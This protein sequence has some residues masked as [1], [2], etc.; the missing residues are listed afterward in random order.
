VGRFMR[1]ILGIIVIVLSIAVFLPSLEKPINSGEKVEQSSTQ[2]SIQSISRNEI[3]RLTDEFI[4][5]LVQDTDL[6]YQ[7]QN[8]HNK[9]SLLQAFEKIATEEVVTPYIDY[10]FKEEHDRLYIVPT[11][12]PPWFIKQNEYDVVQLDNNKVLV[13]QE[14]N[15]ELYGEYGIDIEFTF[16]NQEWKITKIIHQ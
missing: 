16:A 6:N 9:V 2:T 11:E 4:A 5:T 15:S 1:V 14:N 13:K 10:Y 3:I 12:T 7:V 8:Y